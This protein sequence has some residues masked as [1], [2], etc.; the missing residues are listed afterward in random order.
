MKKTCFYKI[1][2]P[3]KKNIIFIFSFNPHTFSKKLIT[4]PFF[5][6]EYI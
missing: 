3:L 2:I 4:H 6:I 5:L 1:I